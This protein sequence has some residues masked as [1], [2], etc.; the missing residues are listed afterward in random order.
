MP[1]ILGSSYFSTS[2]SSLSVQ[3]LQSSKIRVTCVGAIRV[4]TQGR[5]FYRDF[6]H[7]TNLYRRIADK[8]LCPVK[9]W[10]Q[11]RLFGPIANNAVCLYIHD[12]LI[13]SI[14][15][16]IWRKL[17]EYFLKLVQLP[18]LA[19]TTRNSLNEIVILN[20]HLIHY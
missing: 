6:V 18:P 15:F 9:L 4:V 3:Y 7:D 11:R 5:N 12:V 16:R 1:S 17:S 2:F 19:Q 20:G 13:I 8:I 14:I 10:K